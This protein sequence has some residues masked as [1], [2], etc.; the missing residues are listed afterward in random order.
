MKKE[1]KIF[2]LDIESQAKDYFD[3]C[4]LLNNG[5]NIERVDSPFAAVGSTNCYVGKL[6][7]ILFK[8][9]LD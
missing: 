9:Q 3:L 5:W 7:Y 6:I 8:I 1:Y 4:A 2:V